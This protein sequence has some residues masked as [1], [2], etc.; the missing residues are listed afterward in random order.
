[1]VVG[2]RLPLDAD[3]QGLDAEDARLER[4]ARVLAA[5]A[6]PQR[7]EIANGRGPDGE[8]DVSGPR[9]G[10]R[11]DRPALDAAGRSSDRPSRLVLLASLRPGPDASAVP[12]PRDNHRRD[13]G[14]DDD[15][16]RN[17]DHPPRHREV[18]KRDM[19]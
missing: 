17:D 14:R 1:M 7:S 3:K 5:R 13:R 12:L 19:S 9:I 8:V 18:V 15:D 4:A 10:E 6:R 11:L 16:R 2:I